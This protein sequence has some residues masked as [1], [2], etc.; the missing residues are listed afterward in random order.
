ML[1]GVGAN[2]SLATVRLVAVLGAV[3]ASAVTGATSAARDLRPASTIAVVSGQVIGVAQDSGSVAWLEATA[4]GCR[5][6]VHPLAGGAGR[7]LRYAHGCLPTEHDLAL[8][9]GRAAWGGYEEVRCSDTH[10]AVYATDNSRARLVQEIPGDCLGYGTSYQGLATDGSSFFASLLVTSPKPASSR[11]GDGGPCRWRLAGGRIVRIAGSKLVT[12]AGL[13]PTALLAAADGRV[14]LVAP[15]KTFSSNGR[16]AFDWPRAA[17]NGSVEIRDTSSTRVVTSFH[18]LG[19]VRAVAL[20]ATR[21]AVLVDAKATL[22]IEW[23]DSDSGARYGAVTVPRSTARKLSTDGR[24]AAFAA[25]KTVRVLDLETGVQRVVAR[26]T[27]EP[28]GLSVRAGRLVWGENG[29]RTGR[30]VSAAA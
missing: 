3:A 29:A 27:S 5:L 25:G 9:G 15:A 2:V 18:P 13:P 30:I 17:E 12:V 8:A 16:G 10:A 6:R 26:A 28:V 4:A 20:S 14:G 1:S 11:C 22:R 7:V 23:Y 24:F 19:I 21:A